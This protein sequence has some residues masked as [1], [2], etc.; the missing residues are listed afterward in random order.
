MA[1]KLLYVDFDPLPELGGQ[2]VMLS[3]HLAVI[4]FP[5]GGKAKNGQL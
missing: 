1:A 2:V 3:Y 5:V 4:V